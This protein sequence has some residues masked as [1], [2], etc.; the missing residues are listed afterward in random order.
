MQLS[1]TKIRVGLASGLVAGALGLAVFTGLGPAPALSSVA[2]H[3]DDD[4][5]RDDGTTSPTD[6]TVGSTGAPVAAGSRT[7]DAAG[8]GTVTVDVS[9]GQLSLVSAVPNSGWQV[10]V[11]QA[12]GREVEL[13]FRMGS[14]RVQVNVELEDGT[15]RERVRFRDN[16]DG[17]DILIENGV[18]VQAE[19]VEG[20]PGRSGSGASGHGEDDGVEADS[21]RNGDDDGV[22]DDGSGRHGD[23]GP[24]DDHGGTSGRGGADDGPG[25]DHGGDD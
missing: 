24:A 21:G 15:V 14:Q 16:A 19:G 2:E 18:V 22:D 25:D 23:D 20:Q 3:G 12:A 17:T 10:E 6:T 4:G 9:G 1:P 5:G 11:E 13:D 7:F 8:A